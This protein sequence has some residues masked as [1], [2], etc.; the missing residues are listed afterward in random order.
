MRDGAFH[1]VALTK[2]ECLLTGKHENKIDTDWKGFA[3]AWERIRDRLGEDSRSLGRGFAIAWERIRD[4][5]RE[6]SRSLER[7]F[8]IAWERIRD[9]LELRKIFYLMGL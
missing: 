3:I 7:G 5:L 1:L 2:D 8:A 6:D 9:H 4:R